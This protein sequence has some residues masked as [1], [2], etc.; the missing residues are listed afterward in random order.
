MYA[1]PLE[2]S[3]LATVALLCALA[4]WIVDHAVV[5]SV[6]LVFCAVAMF[7]AARHLR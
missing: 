1:K 6:F 2:L 7:G 4:A 3:L 5:G